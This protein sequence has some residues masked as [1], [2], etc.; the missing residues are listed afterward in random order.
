MGS[1]RPLNNRRFQENVMSIASASVG[2]VALADTP[3]TL[4]SSKVPP[5]RQTVVVAATMIV[6]VPR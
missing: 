4:S 6:P 2:Q 3:A 5:K 1:L